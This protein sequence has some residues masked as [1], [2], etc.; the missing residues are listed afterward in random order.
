MIRAEEEGKLSSLCLIDVSSGFDSVSHAY[1]LQKLEL[2]GYNDK[3]L[4]WISS[5]LS[6][7]KQLVQV[8][9]AK[10]R[11]EST[12]IGFPQGGPARPVLFC[13]YSND[14]PACICSNPISWTIGE[15]E[16]REPDRSERIRRK[17]S[18]VSEAIQLKCDVTKS[19]AEK[20]KSMAEW[21]R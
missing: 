6:N 20:E 9:A 17:I 8:Q 3:S 15:L 11:T 1:L 19:D 12:D 10:S 13:E 4:D 16:D 7:R 21:M 18:P 2:Y 5:Y 14:I